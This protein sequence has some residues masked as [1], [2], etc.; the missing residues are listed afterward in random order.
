MLRALGLIDD[1]L[2]FYIISSTMRSSSQVV[3]G[4]SLLTAL[5]AAAGLHRRTHGLLSVAL[6]ERERRALGAQQTGQLSSV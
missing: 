2:F 4:L 3:V 1:I 6:R 5:R